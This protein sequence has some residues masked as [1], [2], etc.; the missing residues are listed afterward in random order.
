MPVNAW[1]V[2]A[3]EAAYIKFDR[4]LA[5]PGAYTETTFAIYQAEKR[6]ETGEVT[7]FSEGV[8]RVEGRNSVEEPGAARI[9]YDAALST[10]VGLD[11]APVASFESLPCPPGP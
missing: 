3:E 7:R 4:D 5:E 1:F 2:V 9:N 10:L 11:G 6:Y 8:I